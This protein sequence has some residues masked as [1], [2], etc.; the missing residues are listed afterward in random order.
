MNLIENANVFCISL[1]G[2]VEGHQFLSLVTCR[3]TNSP[4]RTRTSSLPSYLEVYD[5]SPSSDRK[6]EKCCRLQKSARC[7]SEDSVKKDTFKTVCT[8]CIYNMVK[9]DRLVPKTKLARSRKFDLIVP[10]KYK[11]ISSKR[12]PVPKG[13]EDLS[14]KGGMHKSLVNHLK[15][16]FGIECSATTLQMDGYMLSY[17][18]SEIKRSQTFRTSFI[19][20]CTQ[21]PISSLSNQG[22]QKL[23]VFVALM[24][25]PDCEVLDLLGNKMVNSN[26]LYRRSLEHALSWLSTLGGA[27]SA[28]GDLSSSWADKAGHVSLTQLRIAFKLDDPGIKSRCRIYAAISL[29]QRGYLKSCRDIVRKEY[30]YAV[31]LPEDSDPR[32]RRMCLGVWAKLQY[33]WKLVP[34]SDRKSIEEGLQEIRNNVRYRN[35]Y[36][37][38]EGRRIASADDV[39]S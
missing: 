24:K 30:Q 39:S 14:C 9:K 25:E 29:L 16:P 8:K 38:E 3:P 7:F 23:L 4:K 15:K 21:Q 6:Y 31:S 20:R 19:R 11:V 5:E 17:F 13:S 28:L 12:K 35:V 32:L 27:F 33:H 2:V 26:I 37:L 18:I 22:S 10:K 36:N 1:K 34:L